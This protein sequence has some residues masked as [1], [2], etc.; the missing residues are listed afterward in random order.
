MIDNLINLKENHLIAVF[1]D[2]LINCNENEFLK[3]NFNLKE[4]I[5]VLP[6]FYDY[7]KNYL[8]FFCKPTFNNLYINGAIQEY[9]ENQAEVYYNNNYLH[10]KQKGKNENIDKNIEENESNKLTNSSNDETSSI[11]PD[12]IND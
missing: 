5:E 3:G 11:S 2:N 9:G 12:I 10:K 1:K 7:Y 8:R 6:K 4:C